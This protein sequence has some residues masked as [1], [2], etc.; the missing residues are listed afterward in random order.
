MK[1]NPKRAFKATAI[2]ALTLA[3]P[4]IALLAFNVYTGL[5]VSSYGDN[6]VPVGSRSA[7]IGTYNTIGQTNAAAY[8]SLAVGDGK[9]HD[10]DQYQDR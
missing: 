7:A 3:V 6:S 9:R 5:D 1:T 2:V 4:S 10:A 8:G